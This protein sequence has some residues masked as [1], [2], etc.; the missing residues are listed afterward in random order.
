MVII[1]KLYAEMKN[2]LEEIFFPLYVLSV[3]KELVDHAN[4]SQNISNRNL[5][6]VLCVFVCVMGWVGSSS[7]NRKSTGGMTTIKE[8]RIR[9]HTSHVNGVIIA[10]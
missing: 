8:T 10:R 2:I 1:I 7:W 4:I 9:H 3:L 5:I 6:K